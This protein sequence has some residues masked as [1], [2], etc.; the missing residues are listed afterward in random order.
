MLLLRNLVVLNVHRLTWMKST[1][2]LL[3]GL[4]QDEKDVKIRELTAEL[5]KERKRCAALQEQLEMVL[6]DMENHSHHL[7]K[8]IENIIHSVRE[9]EKEEVALSHG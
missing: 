5:Q 4:L 6:G 1:M 9:I 7:T 8:N 3:F 2:L